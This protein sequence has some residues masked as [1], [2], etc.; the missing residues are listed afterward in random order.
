MCGQ[1]HSKLYTYKGTVK[2]ILYD[3]ELYNCNETNE[4]TDTITKLILYKSDD[5]KNKSKIKISETPL[6]KPYV[7]D[8]DSLNFDFKRYWLTNYKTLLGYR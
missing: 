6:T 4:S 5:N 8:D 7:L 1:V 3:L 2:Q